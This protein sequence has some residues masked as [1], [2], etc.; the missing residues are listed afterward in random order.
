MQHGG[1]KRPWGRDRVR[2]TTRGHVLLKDQVFN[3]TIGR[4]REESLKARIEAGVTTDVLFD[5]AACAKIE[6]RIDEV[7]RTADRGG[8]RVCH[9]G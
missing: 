8:Y 5:E 4:D 2:P 9:G 7:C 3:V 1:R 6:E